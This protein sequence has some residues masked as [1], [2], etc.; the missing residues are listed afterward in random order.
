MTKW[1]KKMQQHEKTPQHLVSYHDIDTSIYYPAL[2]VRLFFLMHGL[3]KTTKPV[4]Q[5][6]KE[7]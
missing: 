3:Q 5:T 2:Q 4:S 1:T 7:M 6:M